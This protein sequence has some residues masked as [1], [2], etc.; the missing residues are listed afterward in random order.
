M[1]KLEEAEQQKLHKMGTDRARGRLMKAG[2]DEETVFSLDRPEL[3]EELA[4]VML[5]EAET[6]QYP[7][8]GG[9]ELTELQVRLME[10]E[11]RRKE[12]ELEQAKLEQETQNCEH[13]KQER[14]QERQ[15]H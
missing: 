10:L 7:A 14:E 1:D 11:E 13:E 2:Y 9:P 8:E 12:R 3:L 4:K 5:A 15:E 6:V